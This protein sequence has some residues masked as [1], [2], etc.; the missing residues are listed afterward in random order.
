MGRN[1]TART[2]TSDVARAILDWQACSCP[3]ALK[4]I[5][6]VVGHICHSNATPSTKVARSHRQV[7]SH[8]RSF[9]KFRLWAAYRTQST[10]PLSGHGSEDASYLFPLLY[11]TR[12]DRRQVWKSGG[13]IIEACDRA[14]QIVHT[15]IASSSPEDWRTWILHVTD[16]EGEVFAVPFSSVL[17]RGLQ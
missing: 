1:V 10:G 3:P 14:E 15:L 17:G 5:A 4:M 2:R 16:D 6:V 9:G 7:L 8:R 11:P 13:G 12:L